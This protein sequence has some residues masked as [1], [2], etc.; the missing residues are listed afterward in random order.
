MYNQERFTD[1]AIIDVDADKSHKL[2]L[3]KD[4][5]RFYFKL[6]DYPPYDWNKFFETECRHPRSSKWR[7][8]WLEGQ[9]LV[10]ECSLDQIGRLHIKDIK[11]DI[12]NANNKYRQHLT[13]QELWEKT[14]VKQEGVDKEKIV[15]F[16]S[17]LNFVN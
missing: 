16:I 13:I 4:L 12:Q 9:Y 5:Y 1:I 15:S 2:E 6:S 8:A 10:C 11:T 3:R 14:K 17:S 7:R